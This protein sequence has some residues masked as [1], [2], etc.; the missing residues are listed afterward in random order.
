[1]ANQGVRGQVVDEN[2]QPLSGLVVGAFDLDGVFPDAPLRNTTP[3]ADPVF[4]EFGRTGADGRFQITYR[5]VLPRLLLRVF[6]RVKRPLAE[7]GPYPGVTAATFDLP[8]PITI[9]R[10]QAEGWLVTQGTHQQVFQ[11]NT[12]E[13]L[14]DNEEA[15]QRVTDAVE[16]AADVVNIMLFYLGAPDVRTV[17]TPPHP[18][19]DGSDA[20]T[21]STRFEEALLA[22]DQNRGVVVRLLLNDFLPK[23][24]P[25]DSVDAVEEFFGDPANAP[26]SVYLRRFPT[27]Q[28]T[29]IHAKVFIF[30]DR[31]AILL[32]SP[33]V[34]EYYDGLQHV[35]DDPRRGTRGG[36]GALK[37]PIHDVSLF[38]EGPAVEAANETFRL[39]WNHAK[40]A[41]ES[42]LPPA[43]VQ[44]A[45]PGSTSL[46][47]VRSLHGER[48][49]GMPA[50]ETGILEG[51]L[52]A[53]R[54]AQDFIYLENQY[55]T[56]REL[57]EALILALRQNPQL[58][59]IVLLNSKVDI[60]L[61]S[62]FQ[63]QT[64][65]QL[66]HGLSDAERE[67][68]GI[69]TVWSHEEGTAGAKSRLLRN[70]V[71]TKV[72]IVD[73]VWA[74]VGSANLDG[75]SLNE[76][77]YATR[78]PALA[79]LA[80]WFGAAATGDPH[81]ARATEVNAQ[82]LDGIAGQPSTGDVALLRRHLWAEHLGF[83]Q[84]GANPG[85][86]A[87]P[88]PADAAV[89]TRPNDGWLSLWKRIANRKLDGIA[90]L[91]ADPV[92]VDAARVLR[93]PHTDGTLPRSTDVDVKYLAALGV[94]TDRIELHTEIRSF[95]FDTGTWK[96]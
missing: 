5:D 36:I 91:G 20:P 40:P 94:D 23:C 78:A 45:E 2:G 25:T 33:F 7:S 71:H 48:F 93:F 16:T 28:T 55:F 61:Y 44:H 80:R 57:V 34:Q 47:I 4:R 62:S 64:M 96:D 65:E 51:Y 50:G 90:V 31:R 75:V 82:I 41:G 49:T 72:G 13:F 58:E 89:T 11:G 24:L 38:I 59:L 15:W 1:V 3:T 26:N 21:T 9:P 79:T 27:P 8:T 56:C 52:R 68:V 30:D 54:N 14:I 95:S 60:P 73:D 81:V 74:T 69:F 63:P 67:R 37:V 70:Y 42:D 85:D 39:H 6:D 22:A 86:P 12:I 43:N 46:Q 88:N 53:I 76:S 87:I 92:V 77:E 32:G 29:P 66:L 35:I 84:A 19:T 17:F 10:A 83:T 18:S